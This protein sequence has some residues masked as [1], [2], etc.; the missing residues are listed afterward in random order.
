[1]KNLLIIA[2]FI[3]VS[4]FAQSDEVNKQ[5]SMGLGIGAAYSGLGANFAFISATDMK[6]ISIGCAEYS[7][8]FGSTCG[9]GAGWIVT[10]LF[11]STSNK[12]GLGIFVTKAGHESYMNTDSLNYS[13]QENEYYGAGVSYN[14]YMNGINKSGFNF[15]LSAIATNAKYDQ[16]YNGLLQ[17]GYQF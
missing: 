11:D 1:L 10:D 13:I 3:S 14:Y 17:I 12:H 16:K 4:T 5:Y 6:Y 8:I 2:S 7:S 15:G 9:F